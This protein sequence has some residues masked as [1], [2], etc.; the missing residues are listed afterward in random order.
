MRRAANAPDVQA[1]DEY[2]RAFALYQGDFLA[3]LPL[4]WAEPYRMECRRR[5]LK[6]LVARLRSPVRRG[7]QDRASRYY[8]LSLTRDPTDEVAARG[9]M[10]LSADMGDINGA[11]KVY[12]VLSEA[13]QQELEDPG[14]GPSPETRSLLAELIEAQ[15]A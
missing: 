2:D 4:S 9:R 7:D 1:L 10:K 8:Q 12:K 3:E 14:A 15:S 5:L 11:R 6:R 13:I